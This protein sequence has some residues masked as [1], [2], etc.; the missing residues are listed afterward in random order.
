[1]VKRNPKYCTQCTADYATSNCDNLSE[2]ERHTDNLWQTNCISKTR[3]TLSAAVIT[4]RGGL[5][6]F[7]NRG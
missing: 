5:E 2:V 3:T 7:Y 4:W 6:M 1:M